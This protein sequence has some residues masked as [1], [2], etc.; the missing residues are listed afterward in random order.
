MKLS[1]LKDNN[2]TNYVRI[3]KIRYKIMEQEN[4]H[5]S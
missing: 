5:I 1:Q 4:I 3:N 2:V